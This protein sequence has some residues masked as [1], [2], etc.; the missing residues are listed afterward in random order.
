MQQ[1]RSSYTAQ[2]CPKDTTSGARQTRA[3]WNDGRRHR[4]ERALHRDL[5][6]GQW[7]AVVSRADGTEE[8]YEVHSGTAY[9]EAEAQELVEYILSPRTDRYSRS[10]LAAWLAGGKQ[11]RVMDLLHFPGAWSKGGE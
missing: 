2:P 1:N 10:F 5:W 11:V 4:E 6:P 8:V 7:E 3:K 9:T